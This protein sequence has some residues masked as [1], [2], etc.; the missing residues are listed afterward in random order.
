M[1]EETKTK[2]K[3]GLHRF[4]IKLAPE[5]HA[6]MNELHFEKRMSLQQLY[7]Y[8][9]EELLRKNGYMTSEK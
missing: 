9:V 6:K 4:M 2:H 3:D 5:T 7:N 1:T 8:A